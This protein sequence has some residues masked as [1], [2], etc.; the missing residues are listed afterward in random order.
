[1]QQTTATPPPEEQDDVDPEPPAEPTLN[2]DDSGE[3]ALKRRAPRK[4]AVAA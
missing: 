2:A 4:R 3:P 1:M